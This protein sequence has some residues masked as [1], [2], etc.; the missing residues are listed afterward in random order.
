VNA[1]PA[2]TYDDARRFLTDLPPDSRV[3]ISYHGDADGTGS[4]ALAVKY[5]ERTERIVVAAL[6]PRKG[7]DLYGESYRDRLR[8]THPDALLVLDQGSRSARVLD[9]VPTLVVDHHDV[10]PG[11]VPAEVYLSG[12]AETPTPPAALMTWRLLSPLTDLSD[13]V[14]YMA[15]GVI[16]D[17]GSDAG[18]PE[19]AAVKKRFGQKHLTE[20]VAL[21]NAAKR[22]GAHDT[23]LSL[24]A[25]LT[26]ETPREIASGL[27]AEY[28]QLAEYR[29]EVQDERLRIGKTAPRFA[30][31]WAL[32]RFSSLCQLHGPFAASWVGR[33]PKHIVIAAND[34]YTPGNVHFSVRTRRPNEN[35]LERLRAF[36]ADLGVPELGQGHAEATGGVLPTATFER[37][38]TLLGF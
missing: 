19:L 7:E 11:G 5:L 2:D 9:D 15:V 34:G 23:V 26:A 21:I 29:Q 8:A 32:L 22:S 10:P 31:D 16:G 6:A 3:T 12:L 18:F 25:I 36:R 1:T 28:D 14:W 17:L 33:L 30:G 37:L 27:I 13:V 20:T 35:L 24:Q 4:A 38:L